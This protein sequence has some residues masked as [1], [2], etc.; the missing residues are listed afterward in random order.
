MCCRYKGK[1]S[2][3]EVRP[4]SAVQ[5]ISSRERLAYVDAAES[6]AL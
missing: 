4:E 1:G 6:D 5:D 2:Q 3:V